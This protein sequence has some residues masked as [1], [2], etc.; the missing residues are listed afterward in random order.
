MDM[1]TGDLMASLW[2][3]ECRLVGADPGSRVVTDRAVPILGGRTDRLLW[4]WGGCVRGQCQASR[5][6][7]VG[8]WKRLK[9]ICAEQQHQVLDQR[10]FGDGETFLV[11]GIYSDRAGVGEKPAPWSQ[12]AT[13]SL[14]PD[15]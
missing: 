4:F 13:P 14:C 11:W 15:S 10:R 12:P 5:R 3:P 8:T 2:F 6:H 7:T 9:L 1:R